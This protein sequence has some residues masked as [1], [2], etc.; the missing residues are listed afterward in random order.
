MRVDR[1]G[2][3]IAVTAYSRSGDS[4]RHNTS[5]RGNDT[6]LV[7]SLALSAR[8]CATVQR[9]VRLRRATAACIRC[10]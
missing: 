6:T 10:R 4:I 3:S 9:L 8:H 5:P 2:N 1:V 7:L